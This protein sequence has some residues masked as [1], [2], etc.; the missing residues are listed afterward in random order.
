MWVRCGYFIGTVKSENK[1]EFDAFCDTKARAHLLTYPGIR[2][3]RILRSAW[4]EDGAPGI[5]QTFELTFDSKE[6]IDVMLKSPERDAMGALMSQILPLFDGY[7][8]HINYE[9]S[10]G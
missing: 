5:Y 1:E 3:V 7:T 10:A 4:H 9:V 2:K 6:A 8:K